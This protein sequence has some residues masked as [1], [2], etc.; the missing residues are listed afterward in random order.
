MTFF[1][2]STGKTHL[3]SVKSAIVVRKT[4]ARSNSASPPYEIIAP[5]GLSP[6]LKV[7]PDGP[8]VLMLLSGKM[9]MQ[10]GAG[11]Q[12]LEMKFGHPV[13]VERPYC[14]ICPQGPGTGRALRISVPVVAAASAPPVS[15]PPVSAPPVSAPPVS[16]PPVSAPPALR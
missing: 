16:A 6:Q 11:D 15:A 5:A 3:A 7:T 2:G 10:V 14:V 12:S 9:H 4:A 8:E 1:R 13:V